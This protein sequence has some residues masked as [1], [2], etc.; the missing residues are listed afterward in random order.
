MVDSIVNFLHLLATTVWIGGMLFIQMILR[1]ALRQTEP[2]QSGRLLGI[3][4][5]K[6]SLAGW[7]SLIVLAMTGYIKTPERMMFD[8]SYG[9]GCILAVK[10]TL[11]ILV[12]IVGMAI[13]FLVLP[14]LRKNTPKPGET[15]SSDFVR[16]QKQLNLLAAVNLVLGLL[17]LAC[18]A[19]LW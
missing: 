11:V 5:R 7:A 18:A 16:C 8:F 4:S 10:H 14:R 13:A 9:L 17:I 1:P 2:Q 12:I 15:P 3:I 19:Q 6:F